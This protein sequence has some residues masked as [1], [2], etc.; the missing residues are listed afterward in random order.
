VANQVGETAAEALAEGS[1]FRQSLRKLRPG[2]HTITM[3]LYPDS[4]DAFRQIRKELYRLG[5]MVAAR[6][7]PPGTP[8][9]GSP[10][11]SKSAAQ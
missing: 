8:I 6:P 5:Y 7:L 3:W 9:S 4:F 1:E 10:D 11:G 2:Y